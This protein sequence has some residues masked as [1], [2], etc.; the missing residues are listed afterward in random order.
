MAR[1]QL[2]RGND[3]QADIQTNKRAD[4]QTD[5]QTYKQ[6]NG[7]TDRQTDRQT[8]KQTGRQTDRQTD[9]QTNGQTVKIFII[10]RIYSHV[11]RLR[12]IVGE[13]SQHVRTYVHTWMYRLMNQ[14]SEYWYIG[15]MLAKSE[16][17][18]NSM[19]ECTATGL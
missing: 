14:V 13:L 4:R 7:Q 19:E 10:R 9:R 16:I 8:Y 5:R 12:D 15:S 11:E 6:T 3:R 1:R 18:K 2:S 17:Q